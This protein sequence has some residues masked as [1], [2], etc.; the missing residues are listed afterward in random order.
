MTFSHLNRRTHLY[1]ALSL[2]PWFLMYAASSA[3]FSHSQYFED[4]DK[5]KGLPLWTTR[6]DRHYEIQVPDSGDLRPLGARILAD[7]GLS[8]SYGV[9][10]QGPDQLNV[11]IYTSIR[12]TQ[13]KY[14]VKERRLVAEDRRFRFDHF[15]TGLHARG[16]FEQDG[17]LNKLWGVV[18]DLVCLGFLLW[19]A[20][21]LSMWWKLKQTRA[22]GWVALVGGF[23]SFALFLWGL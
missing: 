2:L 8:G 14:F 20:T 16:G 12:S 21:G 11:Y 6:F 9:Y 3:V 5:A 7:N 22:W 13:L 18:V 19:I 15:L 17:F 4:L 1:L 10:R 23:V